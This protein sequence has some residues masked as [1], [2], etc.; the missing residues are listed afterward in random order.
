MRTQHGE[1]F[2]IFLSSIIGAYSI[3]NI[4]DILNTILLIISIVNISIVLGLKAYRYIK[5][6]GKL[7]NAEKEDLK[8]DFEELQEN[9]T[10]LKNKEGERN[11]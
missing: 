11:E 9:V 8:Q 7:D 6:D 2:S 5:N 1:N 10:K 3:E 4:N